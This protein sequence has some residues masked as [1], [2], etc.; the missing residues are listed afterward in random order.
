[1][2]RSSSLPPLKTAACLAEASPLDVVRFLHFRDRGGRTQVHA[3]SCAHFGASGIFTCG[4]PLHFAYGTVDSYVGML[5]AIFRDMGRVGH[6]NPCDSCDVKSW[7]KA[8]EKEQQRHRVPIN[9]AKPTFST[10]LRMFVMSA[11]LKLATLDPL[12]PFFP[13]RFLILRD[14]SFFLALWF[15]GD[16]AGDLGRALTKEVVRLGDGSLLFHHTV[17]KTIRSADGQLLVLPR[18]TE[19]VSLCPVAA[20]DRYVGACLAASPPV[21]L[22][23]GYLYPPLAPSLSKIR[24]APLSSSA[25]T[26]RLAVYL[27]DE[28]LTAHGSRAGCAITLEMLGASSEAVREHCKWATA[29]VY[30]HYSK[31]ERVRRLDSSSRLLRSGVSVRGGVSDADSAAHLYELLNSGLA[32]ESAV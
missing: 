30:R 4:C 9:Q 1:M 11:E 23:D 17:G 20:F 32:Q 28:G 13:G 14:L 10:H 12:E 29:E 7:V 6:A 15:S 19:D 31:L 26:K 16:R 24:N 3:F 8:C 22:R 25:A 5:R 2:K 27:P 18:V 21:P